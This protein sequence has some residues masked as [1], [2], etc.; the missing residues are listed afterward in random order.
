MQQRAGVRD[1][2]SAL[3]RRYPNLSESELAELIDLHRRLS[4]L[5]YALMLSDE[6]IGPKL[7]RFSK[8]HRRATRKPF[9]QY[10]ALIVYALLAVVAVGW[11][12]TVAST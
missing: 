5:D 7:H 10:A 12:V 4:A 2:A 3:V 8:E 11:S 6:E 1:Q 9:R